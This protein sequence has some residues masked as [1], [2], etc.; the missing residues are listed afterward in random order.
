[1]NPIAVLRIVWSWFCLI[2][3]VNFTCSQVLFFKGRKKTKKKK[4]KTKQDV[5]PQRTRDENN[6]GTI[7]VFVITA[8]V[9]LK[10]SACEKQEV[11]EKNNGMEWLRVK[12][13]ED[14]ADDTA[15]DF[16]LQLLNMCTS[17]PILTN[18]P[19]AVSSLRHSVELIESPFHELWCYSIP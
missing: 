15:S 4:R 9:I 13:A 2:L 12:H 6:D 8:T 11:D 17:F 19:N 1:M 7:K 5:S 18:S 14:T 3:S 10:C 16:R